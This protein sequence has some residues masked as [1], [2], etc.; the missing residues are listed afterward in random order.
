MSKQITNK[1][2]NDEVKI[3]G[4]CILC[5]KKEVLTSQQILDAELSGAASS[6]CCFFPMTI[7]KVEVKFVK[8]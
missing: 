8:K 5:G 4:K 7:E 2:N 3:T 6:S 1:K